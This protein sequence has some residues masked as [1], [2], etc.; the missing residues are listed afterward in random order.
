M[1]SI[2]SAMLLVISL[3]MAWPGVVSASQ[4][5][6]LQKVVDGATRLAR[7]RLAGDRE[8]PVAR[9]LVQVAL[10]FNEEHELAIEL[11]TAIQ[12]DKAVAPPDRTIVDD[13]HTYSDYIA[14]VAKEWGAG[15]PVMQAAAVTLALLAVEVDPDNPGAQ[16]LVARLEGG[17]FPTEMEAAME[18]FRKR[19]Y[20]ERYGS[21]DSVA[22]AVNPNL[23]GRQ[24]KGVLERVG[25]FKTE[26]TPHNAFNIINLLN[27]ELYKHEVMVEPASDRLQVDSQRQHTKGYVRF[28]GHVRN[29]RG[30]ARVPLKEASAMETLNLLCAVTGLEMRFGNGRVKLTGGNVPISTTATEL[31][32]A[33]E[34]SILEA[35]KDYKDR[36]AVI[37][38]TISGL[39]DR[40]REFISMHNSKLRIY[41]DRT[42]HNSVQLEQLQEAF[43]SEFAKERD[44]RRDEREMDDLY[45]SVDAEV[46]YDW[47]VTGTA[48]GRIVGFRGSR[49]EIRDCRHFTFKQHGKKTVSYEWD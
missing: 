20:P 1:K 46:N 45:W 3:A 29:A 4:S 24:V 33:Y 7:Q 19:R 40:G 26:V 9:K 39:N 31:L 5:R 22:S 36:W 28:T 32:A 2:R 48:I 27:S 16:Q 30:D 43:N 38:G 44:A 41:L 23:S 17:S 35:N 47:R 34:E 37:E 12:E 13:G 10:L 6:Q 18:A 11:N 14:S 15:A 25:S 21:T 49:V 8:D 42:E